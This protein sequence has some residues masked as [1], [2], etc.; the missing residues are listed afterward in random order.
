MTSFDTCPPLTGNRNKHVDRRPNINNRV[1][2]CRL[3][4]VWLKTLKGL[5]ANRCSPKWRTWRWHVPAVTADLVL[6]SFNCTS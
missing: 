2:D 4:L 1:L 3:K 5:R 6:R